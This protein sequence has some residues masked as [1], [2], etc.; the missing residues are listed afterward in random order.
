[1]EKVFNPSSW[2]FK[3]TS[4]KIDNKNINLINSQQQNIVNIKQI[5]LVFLNQLHFDN[6][7]RIDI[8]IEGDITL[9][10]NNYS[11]KINSTTTNNHC[12]IVNN[13]SLKY[14]NLTT[15]IDSGDDNSLNLFFN[16]N[17]NVKK[18][19]IIQNIQIDSCNPLN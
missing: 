14:N 5:E 19:T 9:K 4:L 11:M 18:F 6:E 10:L 13:H 16:T 12:I 15:N 8:E 17:T 7:V 2:D 3:P 1:M